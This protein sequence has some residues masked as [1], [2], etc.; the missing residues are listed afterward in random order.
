MRIDLVDHGVKVTS[1][2]PG[3][4][5]TEFSLVRFKGDTEKADQVYD[6]FT[7]LYAADIA[8]AILFT[9]TRPPHVNIDDMVI[10][11]TAQGRSRKFKRKN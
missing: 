6:G 4:V 10:M 8:E 5:N 11:P 1:I 7:P 9:V 2:D 3:A